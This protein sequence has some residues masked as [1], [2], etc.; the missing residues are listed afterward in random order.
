MNAANI[1]D[2]WCSFSFLCH[3]LFRSRPSPQGLI[4]TA[5]RRVCMYIYHC[6]AIA[7]ASEK[8]GDILDDLFDVEFVI[9]YQR[10]R[11]LQ[12]A[13]T[14]LRAMCF[15][16]MK[17]ICLVRQYKFHL[18]RCYQSGVGVSVINRLASTNA[19][20]VGFLLF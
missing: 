18:V 12:W 16:V 17:L 5:M 15:H 8:N 10:A 9:F 19:L 11:P 1:K 13:S 6:L 3:F 14:A 4:M 20:Y 7:E 2:H